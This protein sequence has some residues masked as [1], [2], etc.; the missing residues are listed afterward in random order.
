MRNE[1]H[2]Q[3]PLEHMLSISPEEIHEAEEKYAW[4]IHG[5]SMK[6]ALQPGD[7]ARIKRPDLVYPDGIAKR[8]DIV[9]YQSKGELVLHRVI[10]VGDTYYT[11][12]GDNDPWS[13][14]IAKD[15]LLGIM[16]GVLR[17]KKNIASTDLGSR[18]AAL[19]HGSALDLRIPRLMRRVKRKVRSLFG[20]A[21]GTR[22]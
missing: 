3:A 2:T 17:G 11:V 19:W 5:R 14:R 6:P 16:V 18:L 8:G 15:Q 9:F 13:E 7:I 21:K 12:R 10:G 22:V 20:G 1:E 4:I